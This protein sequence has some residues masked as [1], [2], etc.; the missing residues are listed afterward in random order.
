MKIIMIIGGMGFIGRHLIKNLPKKNY[1]IV[2]VDNL[3]AQIHGNF[4]DLEPFDDDLDIVYIRDDI[5]NIDGH[6]NKIK[7]VDT[8][9]NMASET[10]T[11][12]SMYQIQKYL[13]SNIVSNS[14]ILELIVQKKIA[15]K[16]YILLSSR[17]VYGQGKYF[18]SL[19]GV[20]YPDDRSVQNMAAG[21]FELI[22]PICR[23][24]ISLCKS[25]EEDFLKPISIYGITKQVQEQIL[26]TISNS[27]GINT[28]IL[29]LQNV[30]GAGQSDVNP[31]TGVLNTFVKSLHSGIDINLYEDGKILRNFIN[32]KDV[33]TAIIKSLTLFDGRKINEVINI[34]AQQSISLLEVIKILAKVN[35]KQLQFIISGDYRLGD[36]RNAV[37]SIEKQKQILDFEPLVNFSEGVN[38]LSLWLKK[39][40]E[41]I[42]RLEIFDDGLNLNSKNY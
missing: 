32:V 39:R 2:C 35:N 17:A 42:K 9:I 37:V 27:T 7:D 3:S 10:G 36:V 16:N 8:I 5:N 29:R 22:C 20:V 21:Q 4:P 40:S 14:K 11:G 24:K 28:I 1:K 38:E 26:G 30:Y 33:T 15:V 19:H 18:C 31:Y 13:N 34:G 23:Q 6:L 41:N 25:K 12:Q